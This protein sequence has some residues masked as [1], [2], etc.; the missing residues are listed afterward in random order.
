MQKLSHYVMVFISIL[1]LSFVLPFFYQQ[2]FLPKIEKTHLF[3]SVA[4][5]K[6]IYTEQIPEATARAR[7]NAEDHHDTIVYMDEDNAYYERVAFEDALPFIYYRNAEIRGKLPVLVGD[8]AFTRPMIEAERRVLE[9][10]ARDIAPNHEGERFYPLMESK[11]RQVS[12][13]FPDDRFRMTD[14]AMEFIF[15]DDNKRQ[16]TLTAEFTNALKQ[17][18]FIFPAQ[19]VSGNFT[20]FK[21][22]EGGIFLSDTKGALFHVI[23]ED[24]KAVVQ[25][26]TLPNGVEA[27]HITVSE[28]KQ[29]RFLGL[30][31]DKN[32]K[33][34]V[35]QQGSFTL[36]PLDLPEYNPDIMDFKLI[37]DPVHKTA[38]YSDTSTIHLVVM[39]YD[40]TVLGKYQREMS[41]TFQTATH[42]V[43]NILF[44]FSLNF[45]A[46]HTR[47]MG[48]Y[49]TI[50]PLLFYTF[51]LGIALCGMYIL[52]RR[53]QRLSISKEQC[54]LIALFGLYAFI[55]ALYIEE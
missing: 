30:F 19:T 42:D 34:Y 1:V 29:Q 38:V 18:G 49:F 55:P 36:I 28:N 33:I 8:T 21:P 26:I 46:E 25:K 37:L 7:A 17:A 2:L 22:Y 3:Y 54:L 47:R 12:L 45:E 35:I 27:R 6:C 5:D 24:N 4:L 52:L 41:R 11:I 53:K 31:L 10:N 39:D 23:R 14:N 20:T 9:L 15:A 48:F 43:H 32:E 44:P 51:I 50:S 13:T 16:E 40:F